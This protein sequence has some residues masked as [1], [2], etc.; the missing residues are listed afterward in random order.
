[1]IY[2]VGHRGAAGLEPENTIGSFERAIEL[3]VDYVE[4][5]VHLT[6]D[7]H[8]V[9]LHDED[10]GRTTNGHGAVRSLDLETVRRL[11]AGGGQRVPTLD[12]VL[13]VVDGR[14]GLF[15]ELKG[16][17]VVDAAL[18]CVAAH[19]SRDDVVF[20][21]FTIEHLEQAKRRDGGC[22]VAPNLARPTQADLA[23]AADMAAWGVG[24]LYRHLTI[25]MVDQAREA[26]LSLRAWNPDTLGEQ[27]AMIALGV[28]GVSTNHP[29]VLLAHLGRQASAEA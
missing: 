18:D 5:D 27:L 1:M 2:V 8:V 28:D 16:E 4:C 29:D 6:R 26:R 25:A 10:V 21:S 20:T 22:S 3:G 17:G 19:P 13:D 9:V 23:A 14:V 7:G 15:C 12:E 24:I 11:D